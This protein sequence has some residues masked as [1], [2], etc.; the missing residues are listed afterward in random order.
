MVEIKNLFV[1]MECFSFET[2][3]VSSYAGSLL[4]W[5][6]RDYSK[7]LRDWR[8]IEQSYEWQRNVTL[9]WCIVSF[10]LSLLVHKPSTQQGYLS[11]EA[12]LKTQLKGANVLMELCW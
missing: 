4:A 9:F 5:F 8:S 3:E 2:V 12:V 1:S 11:G 6:P 10:F 7:G